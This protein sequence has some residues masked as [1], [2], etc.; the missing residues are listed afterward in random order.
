MVKV[1]WVPECPRTHWEY[2]GI[3]REYAGQ[4]Q[5]SAVNGTEKQGILGN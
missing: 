1:P 4:L 3:D 2:V 5:W